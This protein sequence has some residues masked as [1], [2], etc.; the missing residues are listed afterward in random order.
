MRFTTSEKEKKDI[1]KAWIAISIAFAIALNGLR[2]G[3]SQAFIIAALTVGVGFLLHELAHKLVAQHYGCW[4]EFRSFD[5]ML[6]FAILLSFTGI[7]FAA[8]GAVM[9]SGHVTNDRNGKISAAGPITNFILA[10]NSSFS[11]IKSIFFIG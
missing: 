1:I 10:A 11:L 9:I 7:I 8:P 2:S 3:F 6:F 4:A 5:Q